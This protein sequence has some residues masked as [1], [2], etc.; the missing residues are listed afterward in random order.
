MPHLDTENYYYWVDTYYNQL[1]NTRS[2]YIDPPPPSDIDDLKLSINVY[3]NPND[4]RFQIDCPYS[5]SEIQIINFNLKKIITFYDSQIDISHL[6]DGIYLAIV[7]TE[8]N[9]VYSTKIIKQ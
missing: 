8:R 5:I 9:K 2:Y 3:P 4:G 6:P 1:C 7:K